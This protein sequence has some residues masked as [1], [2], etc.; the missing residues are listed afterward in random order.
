[1]SAMRSARVDAGRSL[2]PVVPR[3]LRWGR[4]ETLAE[5]ARRHAPEFGL[6]TEDEYLQR[7]ADFFER[8]GIGGL[9]TKIDDAGIIRIYDPATNTFGSYGPSGTIRTFFKPTS[10]DYWAAQQGRLQ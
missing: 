10:K 1:M 4:T 7:A 5:H 6:R 2:P 8:G 3:P 9:P